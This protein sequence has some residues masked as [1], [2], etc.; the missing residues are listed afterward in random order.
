MRETENEINLLV[1]GSGMF[2][3]P[4]GPGWT[5]G[6]RPDATGEQDTDEPIGDEFG[7]TGDTP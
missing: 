7:A 4:I 1:P 5:F 3:P 2:D 6:P